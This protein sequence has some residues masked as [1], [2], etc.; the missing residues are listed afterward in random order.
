M[1]ALLVLTFLPASASAQAPIRDAH[2]AE[3]PPGVSEQQSR[4]EANEAERLTLQPRRWPRGARRVVLIGAGLTLGA[5]VVGSTA[6]SPER[7]QQRLVRIGYSVASVGMLMS[8]SAW[9]VRLRH[10]DPGPS[11]DLEGRSRRLRTGYAFLGLGL[12]VL[13][14][15][16]GASAGSSAPWFGQI[17]GGSLGAFFMLGVG[18]P[19]LIAGYARRITP[20]PVSLN[21]GLGHLQLVGH[22]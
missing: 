20:P 10:R 22:F 14:A 13:A 12:V 1:L 17:I 8:F 6:V 11:V 7:S 16:M 3:V 18:V 4:Y 5:V 19:F 2:D 21:V 15:G 9:V